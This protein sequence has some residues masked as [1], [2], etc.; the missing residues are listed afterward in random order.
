MYI[1]FVLSIWLLLLASIS[2]ITKQINK[3]KLLLKLVSECIQEHEERNESIT[4]NGLKKKK[5]NGNKIKF[6]FTSQPEDNI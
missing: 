3:N 2:Y 6:I 4:K 1:L 5:Q